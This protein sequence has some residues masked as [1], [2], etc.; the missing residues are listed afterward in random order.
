[1]PDSHHRY[2]FER[3]GDHDFQ[4][5][6]AALL[7]TQFPDFVPM[8]LRQA[9]GGRDGLRGNEP[10]KVIVYQT[11]WSAHGTEKSPSPGS[12]ASLRRSQRTCAGWPGKGSATTCS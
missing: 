2:L 11:K 7:L 10:G 8:A 4:Q 9:D 3:L 12:A 1:V 5:L 6:V